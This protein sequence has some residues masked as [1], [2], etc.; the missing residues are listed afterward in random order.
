MTKSTLFLILS[1]YLLGSI[2]FSHLI[3]RWRTGLAIREVGEGNVGSRNVWHVTGPGW[4]ALAFALDTLKGLSV[5]LI[6]VAL[7]VPLA[8]IGLA[9]IA[10][11]LGHQFSIFLHGQ[12]GK[13]LATILGVMLGLSPLST[14]SGLALMGLAYLFFRDFNPSVIAGALGIIFLPLLFGQPLVISIYAL[15]MGLLAGVKKL[16]DRQHEARVWAA[17]PWEGSARPGF[18][19]DESNEQA[20][21]PDTGPC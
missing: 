16:L 19:Q 11:V 12:G 14:I 7:S 3:T 10:A 18:H 17:H 9:G 21:S 2:P 6:G 8:S 1:A 15:G 13:G 5:F 4:G 20:P